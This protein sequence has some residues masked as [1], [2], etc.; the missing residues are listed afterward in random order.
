MTTTAI[1]RQ[2]VIDQLRDQTARQATELDLAYERIAE[3][4]NRT[5]P[6]GWDAPIET[7]EQ[8]QRYIDQL[9]GQLRAKSGD[10][11][12]RDDRCIAA[13]SLAD[14]RRVAMYEAEMAVIRAHQKTEHAQKRIN[15]LAYEL[16]TQR[17][18]NADLKDDLL[19]TTMQC[20]RTDGSRRAA[21]FCAGVLL[22][23]CG[24]LAAGLYSMAVHS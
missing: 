5:M 17:K 11:A 22:L 14:E 23:I 20:Y 21:W 8:V 18:R 12:L 19:K 24:L 4:K 3:L 6:E 2:A 15:H 13:Q 7:Y 16:D 9:E 10:I 1:S